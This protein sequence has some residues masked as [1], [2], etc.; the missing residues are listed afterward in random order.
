VNCSA[1]RRAL[2]RV[3]TF[4]V[5]AGLKPHRVELFS[6]RDWRTVSILQVKLLRFL[7]EQIIERVGGR[8]QICVDVRVM[9]ATN[10][11]LKESI[12]EGRFREDLYYRL[13]V[14]TIALPPLRER[15]GDTMLLATSLLHKYSS[16][17]RKKI[18]GFTPQAID[19]LQTY[20][21]PG[22]VRELENR[23]KRAVIMAEGS[24]I[25]PQ[26]LELVSQDNRHEA[27]D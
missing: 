10:R 26:D 9:A 14:V 25:T 3:H 24:R 18:T 6:G 11:D 16:E 20:R 15:E 7:Q 8:E 1:T 12:K 22:N 5:R 13:G 27:A 21:W 4:S 23:I 17:N 19:S 2:L